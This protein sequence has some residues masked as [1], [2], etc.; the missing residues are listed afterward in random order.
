VADAEVSGKLQAAR[1]VL[2]ERAQRGEVSQAELT[3]DD[4]ANEQAILA[5][6]RKYDAYGPAWGQLFSRNEAAVAAREVAA[7]RLRLRLEDTQTEIGTDAHRAAELTLS[8]QR[9]QVFQASGVALPDGPNQ[10]AS[11]QAALTAIQQKYSTSADAADFRDRV[12]RLVAAEAA[13]QRAEWGRDVLAARRA[14]QQAEIAAGQR[15]ESAREA[16]SAVAV[17]RAPA[18]PRPLPRR[19]APTFVPEYLAEMPEPARVLQDTR[20]RDDIDTAA[21]GSAT[22]SFLADTIRQR[23]LFGDALI[24]VPA[25]ERLDA[26]LAAQVAVQRQIYDTFDPACIGQTCPRF[27]FRALEAKYEAETQSAPVGPLHEEIFDRYFST[28]WCRAYAV[29]MCRPG[30]FVAIPDRDTR[31]A[32]QAA[33][34]VSGA[35]VL[36]AAIGSRRRGGLSAADPSKLV[37]GFRTYRVKS[38]TGIV[39]GLREGTTSVTHV[40]NVGDR[41]TSSSEEHEHSRFFI[42]H[43]DGETSV[44]LT[45]VNFALR[46]GHCVSAVWVE[47][48]RKPR[49]AYILF[50]NHDTGQR[51]VMDHVLRRILKPSRWALFVLLVCYWSWTMLH[52]AFTRSSHPAFQLAVV[53][54]S[55]ATVAGTIAWFVMRAIVGRWRTRRFI[56][57]DAQRLLTALDARAKEVEATAGWVSQA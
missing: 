57:H 20:G 29:D 37:A 4:Q 17:R 21:R 18:N 51:T 26:Y 28:K 22:L 27:K 30:E 50:R 7:T 13:T 32:V 52:F 34:A 46:N 10:Q 25:Q 1:T 36:L 3:R 23:Y 48:G 9:Y 33:A 43:A 6:H 54:A 45:D 24:P 39:K 47:R 2:R 53:T 42:A 41:I 56:K 31:M 11:A 8:V 14:A 12:A 55:V 15:A 16:A 5:M 44:Q 49:W 35:L 40:Y 38:V 19:G